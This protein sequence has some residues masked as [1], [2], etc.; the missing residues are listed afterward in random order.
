MQLFLRNGISNIDEMQ[1]RYDEV[2]S[3]VNANQYAL[4]D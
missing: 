2:S 3:S 4:G 1:R